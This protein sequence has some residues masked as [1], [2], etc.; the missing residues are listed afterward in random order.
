MDTTKKKGR[1]TSKTDVFLKVCFL[2]LYFK[3]TSEYY[4]RYSSL[5]RIENKFQFND[6]IT[7]LGS[8]YKCKKKCNKHTVNTNSSHPA[9]IGLAGRKNKISYKE[10]NI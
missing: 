3:P 9:S 1:K 10:I 7:G 2:F 5:D 8:Y 6:P 4:F